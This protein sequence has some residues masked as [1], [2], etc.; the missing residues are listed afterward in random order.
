MATVDI[1]TSGVEPYGPIAKRAVLWLL[2]L[3]PFFYTTYGFANWAASQR[4]DVG[5]IVHDWER[6]IPFLAWTIIPYWSINAFYALSLFVNRSTGGVD[7]LAGRYLTAQIIAVACFLAFPLAASFVRPETS[8]LPGFMFDVLGGFDKPFNQA[9][10]LHIAL[11]VIIWDHLRRRLSPPLA[12]LW[13]LWCVLIAASVLTTFQHHFIDIPTGAL[14]GFLALWA[15]PAGGDLPFSA[16]TWTRDPKRRRL[17]FFYGVAALACLLGASAGT[18]KSAIWLLLL[19]PALAL[20]IVSFGYAGAGAIVFQ[21]AADGTTSLASRIILLPYRLGARINAWAWTRKLTPAA[22]ISSGVHLGRFPRAAEAASYDIVIDL[23]AEL[24]KPSP[25]QTEW[26][27][28]PMLDL[29]RPEPTIV[30]AA[31][32]A[33]EGNAG[34]TVL[35]C[36]ALGFQRSA[37]V[38]SRWLVTTGRAKDERVAAA[39]LAR[40]GR[41]VVLHGVTQ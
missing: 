15:F 24:A 7:R 28:F 12:G 31:A 33:I 16:F 3:A 40:S 9:P 26:R 17:A 34:K 1:P 18:P 32:A 4:T 35:V 20:A 36:C 37:L 25:K 27:A 41:T 38:V 39:L 30:D 2:F 14:L 8:G 5:S 23:A 21:K 10:S 29:V 22:E 11:T 6:L 19:W 13:S